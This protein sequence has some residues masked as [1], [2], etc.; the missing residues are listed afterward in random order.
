M[1][2]ARKVSAL[3]A[4]VTAL[5]T[6]G[7]AF[8]AAPD[9]QLGDVAIADVTTPVP[10]SVVNSAATEALRQKLTGP[11]LLIVRHSPQRANDAESELRAAVAHARGRF[12]ALI[13][14]G[15]AGRAPTEAEIGSPAYTRA[16]AAVLNETRGDLPLTE[17]APLWMRGMTDETFLVTLT[18]PLRE[19]M[20]IPIVSDED[21]AS[22]AA[23]K[24]VR[25]VPVRSLQA[26]PRIQD[27][28]TAGRN[29]PPEQ[30]IT[31]DHARALMEYHF[32]GRPGSLGKFVAS[33][34]R[35]NTVPDPAT[36]TVVRA[37]QTEGV[38]AN[39]E[40]AAAQIV[41]RKGQTIDRKALNA[42]A[43]M[44]EKTLIGT[45]QNQLEQ[46]AATMSKMEQRM[47]WILASVGGV[48]L[49]L[50]AV[51]WR[52]RARHT[53]SLIALATEHPFERVEPP[54]FSKN[55]DDAAWRKRALAAEAKAARAHEAIRSGVLGWMR[56]KVFHALSSQRTQ[57][58]LVQEKAEAEMRE[59][60]ERLDR[61]HVPLQA[62]ML[63][64]EKRI[65]ELENALTEKQEETRHL[66]TAQLALA[67]RKLSADRFRYET[68]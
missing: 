56:E 28:E 38:T 26:P 66:I 27:V 52:L 57:L 50:I 5:H 61:L 17:L 32:A 67:R 31:L 45:L 59:L 40:Y 29:V 35:E 51:L 34:I 21:A 6:V 14:E 46:P 47:T 64:Y 63:A 68:N 33:F 36:T 15:A 3:L 12:L 54:T 20:S 19:V 55:A 9:Y 53:K 2:R 4:M 22:L 10:L 13:H 8:T 37:R 16:H 1:L 65:E 25:L 60:E 39:D 42:L 24:N 18:E 58:L 23:H 43:A 30:I 7:F 49:L 41:V 62:R 48:F 11:V 44:R